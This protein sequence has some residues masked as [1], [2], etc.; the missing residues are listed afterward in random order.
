M[1]TIIVPIWPGASPATDETFT[2]TL[3]GFNASGVTLIRD[4]GTGT[5]LGGT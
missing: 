4:T 3:T 1:R 2:I 5:I